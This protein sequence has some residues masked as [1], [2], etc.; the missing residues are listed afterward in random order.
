MQLLDH[1][2]TA[3]HL[4]Q[5]EWGKVVLEDEQG[6][7]TSA[8]SLFYQYL[9]MHG[10]LEKTDVLTEFVELV[11]QYDT[12]EWERNGNYQAQRLNALFF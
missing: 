8:T 9:V 12:W 10:L 1:H 7:L 3:L 5:Y 11:R 4:N 2:Q 6:L